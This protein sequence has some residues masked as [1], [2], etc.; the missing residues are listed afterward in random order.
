[1]KAVLWTSLF[2]ILVVTGLGIYTKWFNADWAQV[3]SEF[4]YEQD[5]GTGETVLDEESIAAQLMLLNAKLDAT[6]SGMTQTDVQVETSST[7]T[8]TT[9]TPPTQEELII[10]DLEARI[11]DLEAAKATAQ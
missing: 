7:T 1:M 2:W 3:V 8:S 4:V 9:T 6:L 10:R 5:A 11:R